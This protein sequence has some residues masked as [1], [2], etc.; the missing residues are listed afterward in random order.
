MEV[1]EK[2]ASLVKLEKDALGQSLKVIGDQDLFS[3]SR[4]KNTT[5]AAICLD[6]MDKGI[7]PRRYLRNRPSISLAQQ[8][9]L[10]K[11][12][13]AVVGAGGLGGHVIEGLCRLGVGTLHIFDPDRFDETNLNRQVFSTIATLDRPKVEVSKAACHLINPFVEIITHP[14]A[15]QSCDQA[16]LFSQVQVIVDALDSSKDRLTLAAIATACNVPLIHGAV[17]GFEGRVMVVRPGDGS[18]EMLYQ[19]DAKDLAAEYVLGT[20][21]FSPALIG[22]FQMM[23]VTQVLLESENNQ[24]PENNQTGNRR[25]I[26]LDL[27]T[28][29]LDCFYL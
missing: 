2:L 14:V 15:V 7:W 17:A 22:A 5:F 28:P 4:E 13:V 18:M 19:E 16:E 25:M 3:L 11:S 21:V 8:I 27:S 24:T 23:A 1:E 20:P 9:T 29:S 12:H 26:H 6:C 10:S